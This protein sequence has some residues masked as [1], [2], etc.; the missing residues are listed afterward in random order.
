MDN[1]TALNEA[2]VDHAGVLHRVTEY[3]RSPDRSLNPADVRAD[4]ACPLG[5]WL[6]TE[7]A[8]HEA[9]PAYV[10]LREAHTGF[11]R[12][13]GEAVKHADDH[14]LPEEWLG[15]QGDIR[16]SF[17]RLCAALATMTYKIG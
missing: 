7:G 1:I 14:T 8:V 11:H 10:S 9:L 4:D 3:V 12:T 6:S 17:V 5:R 13:S 16:A 15:E 2:F